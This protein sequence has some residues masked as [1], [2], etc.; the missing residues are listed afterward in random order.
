MSMRR[1]DTPLADRLGLRFALV[2]APMAGVTTPELVAAVSEAG[3][4]GSFGGAMSSPDELRSAINEIS[5]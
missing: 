1:L 4:L 2:Q 5:T 3:A